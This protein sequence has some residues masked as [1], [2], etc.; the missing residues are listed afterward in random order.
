M[1]QAVP[2]IKPEFPSVKDIS[3]DYAAIVRNNYYT[4]GGPFEQELTAKIGEYVGRDVNTAL[5]ASATLGLL[6]AVK[7]AF[8]DTRKKALVA[9]FTFAAGP[10]ALLWCGFQPVF[11][12]I[13]DASWQPSLRE[14]TEYIGLHHSELAGVLLTNTFGVGNPE[15]AQ[16]EALCER[17]ELPLVID[18]AAGFGS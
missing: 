7:A 8:I 17:F 1:S 2:F 9:S 14:A 5:V 12:D 13:D 10:E 6:L 4:N 3:Q 18:S 16:W 11:M 15:I